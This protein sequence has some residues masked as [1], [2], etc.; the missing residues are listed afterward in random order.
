MLAQRSRELPHGRCPPLEEGER[1]HHWGVHPE[2]VD[3]G[4][5]D[6][7]LR[8]GDVLVL[9]A[10]VLQTKVV[11]ATPE[12]A[13]MKL[14][15]IL[16]LVHLPLRRFIEVAVVVKVGAVIRAVPVVVHGLA[17]S[18]VHRARIL[19]VLVPRVVVPKVDVGLFPGRGVEQAL[20]RHA[21]RQPVLSKNP[22]LVPPERSVAALVSFEEE[23]V[24]HVIHDHVDD[25]IHAELMR[26]GSQIPELLQ[27]PEALVQQGEILHGVLVIL[28]EAVLENRRNPDGIAT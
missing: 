4:A 27:R 17:D 19:R 20:L 22:V 18:V 10:L 1:H 8:H 14:M 25:D 6:Q 28:V 12:L 9:H 23:Q 7:R 5:S 21:G 15:G 16:H 26:S 13:E 2:A 3:V 11:V 24:G